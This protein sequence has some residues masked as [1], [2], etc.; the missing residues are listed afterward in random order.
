MRRGPCG[1][2]LYLP[3][4]EWRDFAV[5]LEEHAE[6]EVLARPRFSITQGGSLIHIYIV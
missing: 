3:S 4:S 1:R 5:L 2:L 6:L